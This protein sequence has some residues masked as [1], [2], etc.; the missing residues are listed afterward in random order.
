MKVT[1]SFGSGQRK[2]TE[3]IELPDDDEFTDQD[4]DAM[5]SDWLWD[6]S[7]A[8]WVKEDEE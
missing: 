6:K 2:V 1:F 5:L 7:D 3:T 4:L 8:H